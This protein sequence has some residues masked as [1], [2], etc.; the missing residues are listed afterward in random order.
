MDIEGLINNRTREQS[1]HISNDPFSLSSTGGSGAAGDRNDAA[2]LAHFGFPTLSPTL[3]D[4]TNFLDTFHARKR[5]S[6][7]VIMTD[8]TAPTNDGT[9]LSP[10]GR[11]KSQPKSG[12]M[13]TKTSSSKD[14]PRR[15]ALQAC[16]I[17]RARKTKC[18]NERPTCGSCEALG[19]DCSYNDA[20]ASK[21]RSPTRPFWLMRDWIRGLSW[22]W[23]DLLGLREY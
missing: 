9:R 2:T 19:V 6:Q 11:K 18:D 17:C 1:M 23:T 4:N 8:D 15:R 20:P 10:P 14:Y 21:Y 5:S 3:G 16:Q 7:D 13:G 12:D 22:C